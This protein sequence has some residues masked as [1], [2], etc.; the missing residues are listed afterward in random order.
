MKNRSRTE[1]IAEI[2]E[3]ANTDNGA[4]KT[5]I[6]YNAFLSYTQLKQYLSLLLENDLVNYLKEEQTY[7]TT[8]KGK[9]FLHLYHQLSFQK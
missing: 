8:H 2:L 4:N 1:I 6:M 7:R 9:H 5:R 3:I